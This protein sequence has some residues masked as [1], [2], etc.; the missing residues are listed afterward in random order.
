MRI[1]VLHREQRL[2]GTPEEVFPFFAD[3][4]NLEAI[5]PPLLRFR[6][7]TPRPLD[8]R[9]GTFLQYRLRVHGVPVTWHTIIQAWDPPHRF[10]DVQ[11]RGPYALWHHTHTFTA[12]GDHGTLMT[13][14]VRYAIGFGPLGELAHR[15]LVRRDVEAIFA[16]RA[17]RVPELLRGVGPVRGGGA[18]AGGADRVEAVEDEVRP[19]EVAR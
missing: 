9:A 15:A 3:A 11:V 2:D 10:V 19:G 5:T 4:R 17:Q 16:F 14:T 12:T 8:V 6:V 7:V 1:H 18:L 13:D